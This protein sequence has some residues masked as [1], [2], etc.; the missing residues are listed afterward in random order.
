MGP[1]SRGARSEY[2]QQMAE[3]TKITSH[4]RNE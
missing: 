1:S 4:V 2:G 3:K